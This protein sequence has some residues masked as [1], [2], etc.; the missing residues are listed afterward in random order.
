[1]TFLLYKFFNLIK[2]SKTTFKKRNHQRWS[3]TNNEVNGYLE[4]YYKRS[5]SNHKIVSNSKSENFID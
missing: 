1:M 4:D 5:T 2:Y 3:K